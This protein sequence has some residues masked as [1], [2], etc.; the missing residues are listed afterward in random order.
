MKIIVGGHWNNA[1]N[2]WTA[3]TEQEQDITKKL[4]WGDE[5][6]D[7]IFNEHVWEHLPLEGAIYFAKESLRVLV[8]GGVLRIACP[9]IDKLIRFKGDDLGKHY[10]DTQTKHYYINE[11]EALK[12]LGFEGVREEP[13][14]FMLD[15][16]FKG[17]N[18][19]M[20]WTSTMIKKVLEKV[21]FSEVHICN[22][23][24]TNFNKEDC[25]ERTIRGVDVDT[26]KEKFNLNVFDPETTVIEAKK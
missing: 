25:L 14:M 1:P 12:A 18:H 15:S 23:G 24:E 10:C 17:H 22:P 19:R 16:L 4:S 5:T 11:D 26:L 6:I 9:T 3:L 21:G 13:I 7:V 2:G 20:I 8:K